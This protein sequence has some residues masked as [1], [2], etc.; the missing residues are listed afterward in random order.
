MTAAHLSYIER[1]KRQTDTDDKE[2]QPLAGRQGRPANQDFTGEDSRDETLCE[3]S[4]TVVVITAQV[5]EVLYPESQGN[6]CVGI[7]TSEH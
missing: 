3:V 4:N 5:K 7:M 6:T 1:A 2:E